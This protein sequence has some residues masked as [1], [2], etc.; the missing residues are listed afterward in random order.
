MFVVQY[1][2]RQSRRASFRILF[3]AIV[4]AVAAISSVGVFSARLEAALLRDAT[5]M[6]GGDL[7]VESRRSPDGAEWRQALSRPEFAKLE[8]AQSAVF[9][10]VVPAERTDLLVSVKAVSDTYPLRGQLL[11]RNAQGTDETIASGP[12]QGQVWVDQ[13]ILGTLGVQIGDSISLGTKSFTIGRV[14]LIE[15]DRGGG[16]VNFAPRA[17]INLN[18]LPETGLVGV[19]SRIRWK[20]YLAGD[21]TTISAFRET[22]Q[23]LLTPIEELETVEGGRPE[24]SGT[25]ERAE[26]FLSMAALI[27]TLVACVGIGLVAHLFAKEQARELAVLKSLGFTPR[28]LTRLWLAGLVFLTLSGGLI[29]VAIGWVSHWGL[30]LLLADVVGVELPMAGLY[31][32]P[33]G[34]LLAAVLLTGFGAVPAW[35]ALSSPAV[36]V[37]RDQPLQ[38][39]WKVLLSSLT[40]GLITAFVVCMIIV[41]N[42]TLALLLFGGFVAVSLA[43]GLLFWGLIRLLAAV[44]GGAGGT[45]KISIFKSMSKRSG[46]L[47]LQGVSLSLG[48]SALLIL[49]VVQGD[50]IDRWQQAVPADA[51][52]RFVFN[53]QPDQVEPVTSY[54]A[55]TLGKE[56][57]LYPMVRGRLSG[58]NGVTL[59]A[60][61]FSDERAK[62]LVER[63][64][65][66]SF[67]DH[68]PLYNTIVEGNWFDVGTNESQVSLETSVAERLGLN[69]GDE[70]TFD[71]AGTPLVAKVTSIR[72]LRW[73]SMQVNFYIIFPPKVLKDFPQTWITA[74]HAPG[75]QAQVISRTMVRDYP[76]VTVL[77]TALILGQIREILSKVSRAVQF[78]FLF[79][80]FAGGLVV[81]ACVLTGARARTRES[82]IYRAMGAS[83]GQLQRAAWAELTVLGGLAGFVSASAAQGLGWGIAHFI[84]EFEYVMSIWHYAAGVLI[85]I[86]VSIAFGAWS[87]RK[88]CVA[89]VMRTLRQATV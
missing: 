20:S 44:E 85:G 7:V 41:K 65:N 69:L 19:G 36:A 61:S 18:D 25:L 79:T 34:V 49:A 73:D 23:P 77:D 31:Y 1:W 82:A 47:V 40:L 52:N 86:F 60:D 37:L 15:P 13:G 27:G 58:V 57:T 39:G 63:E 50:L 75:E 74:F 67:T 8:R 59:T 35:F 10:S 17:M 28:S 62:R 83:S 88:V 71:F 14:I 48:L 24:V 21:S 43:F 80:V 68:L 12:P 29:G 11:T 70:L 46:T 3:F 16:F 56:A 4:L 66:I 64:F 89:P 9:P 54:L 53:I 84:F 42:V 72:D 81:V 5:H 76:N 87:V 55:Q 78:I 6:L 22:I 30:M 45:G 51:P 38:S 32:L 2:L 33:F 26:S